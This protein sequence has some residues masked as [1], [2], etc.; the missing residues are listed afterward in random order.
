MRPMIV[1]TVPARTHWPDKES[2]RQPLA[3][4]HAQPST[5]AEP[6]MSPIEDPARERDI[7]TMMRGFQVLPPEFTELN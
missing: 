5:E 1:V 4:L 6:T 7:E 2:D 3:L